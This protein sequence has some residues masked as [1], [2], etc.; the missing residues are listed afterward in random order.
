MKRTPGIERFRV[1][2]LRAYR[3]LTV[4]VP[5]IP[6]PQLAPEK[7]DAAQLIDRTFA[8]LLSLVTELISDSR[9]QLRRELG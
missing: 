8:D 4:P 3:R 6:V 7:V 5:E 2:N 9:R 1:G